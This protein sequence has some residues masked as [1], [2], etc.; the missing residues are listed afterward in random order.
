M[1]WPMGKGMGTVRAVALWEWGEEGHVA[2]QRSAG[3]LPQGWTRCPLTLW[4]QPLD[5][6]RIVYKW[7]GP[8]PQAVHLLLC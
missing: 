3:Q 8:D 2:P 4:P 6:T 7:T 5:L 1:A